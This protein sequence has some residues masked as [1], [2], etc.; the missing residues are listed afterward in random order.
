[1]IRLFEKSSSFEVCLLFFEVSHI[2]EGISNDYDPNSVGMLCAKIYFVNNGKGSHF[3]CE[4]PIS[5]NCVDTFQNIRRFSCWKNAILI[6]LFGRSHFECLSDILGLWHQR[7][8][9]VLP[10]ISHD[11]EIDIEECVA[12]APR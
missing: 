4:E 5:S 9:V 7:Y 3:S 8:P 11:R 6:S 1:M 2:S 10:Y 12:M